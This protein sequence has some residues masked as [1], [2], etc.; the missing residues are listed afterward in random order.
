MVGTL[1]VIEAL[2]EGFIGILL[3]LD[4]II[5]WLIAGAYKIFMAIAGARL[6]SSD[7]YTEIANKIYIV[8]GVVMLFVL[9]YAILRGIID[10]EKETKGEFGSKML[11]RVVTAVIG[12]AIAPFLFNFMYQIQGKILEDDIIGRLFFRMDA[13]DKYDLSGSVDVDGTNVSYG[14]AETNPDEY[15]KS[16]GGAI[17]ATNLWQAFFF[18]AEG[19][20]ASEIEADAGEYF[21]SA[22]GNA[23]LCAGGIALGAAAT[24]IP[25]IGWI[26]GPILM[27]GTAVTAC[28]SSV[29]DVQAGIKVSQQTDGKVTL[30]EAYSIAAGSGEFSIFTAFIKNYAED[31]EI[32]YLFLVSTI[33]GAFALY[34]FVSFSIDMGVRAAMLAYLQIIAPIPLIL[35]VL[36]KF[37]DNL[38]KYISKV[39]GTF[40][41]VFVRIS[42]VYVVVY[43]IC[44][45]T[46]LF[47][48]VSAWQQTNANMGLSQVQQVLAL[49]LLILGL[50]AFCRKAPEIISETLNLPKGNMSLG[51]GKKLADGGYYSGKS[52]VGSGVKGAVNAWNN[53]KPRRGATAPTVGQRA[54]AALAGLGLSTAKAVKSNFIGP[55]RKEAKTA[56]EAKTLIDKSSEAAGT[57][58]QNMYG[59]RDTKDAYNEQAKQMKG[60]MEAAERDMST[61]PVGSAAYNTAKEK[62]E[63]ALKQ[64]REAKAIAHQ[65]TMIGAAVADLEERAKTWAVGTVDT[66]MMDR[67]ANFLAETRDLY[68][69]K[70]KSTVA[71][72]DD[73]KA[74]NRAASRAANES[75]EQFMYHQFQAANPGINRTF[76]EFVANELK[77]MD[78]GAAQKAQELHIKELED[79]AK[80]VTKRAVG[81]R[82]AEAASGIENDTSRAVTKYLNDHRAEF[83]AF[84]YEKIGEEE[85]TTLGIKVGINVQD[86]MTG[87]F[88]VSGLE[89]GITD[90]AN[91]ATSSMINNSQMRIS[92][93]NADGPTNVKLVV[94]KNNAGTIEYKF[95]DTSSGSDVVIKTIANDANVQE[96]ISRF[97]REKGFT[98]AKFQTTDTRTTASYDFNTYF[99][100]YISEVTDDETIVMNLKDASNS[101]VGAVNITRTADEVT[102]DC[103]PTGKLKVTTDKNGDPTSFTFTDSTGHTYSDPS[104][105][106]AEFNTALTSLFSSLGAT[107]T[108]TDRKKAPS[109]TRM[110]KMK[111]TVEQEHDKFTFSAEYLD[112]QMRRRN[113]DAKKKNDQGK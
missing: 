72:E 12:L 42:V 107:T 44:H 100:K 65:N 40:M 10:P 47:G 27:I 90:F 71:N 57:T 16:I 96:N 75:L 101:N 51:I 82:M 110:S 92:Y 8:I 81:R 111:D 108:A 66:T 21:A 7:A 78:K 103:G 77:S 18:P 88:G 64:Y 14:S 49:A 99:K 93:E 35:Q 56:K 62:Y 91:I 29:N 20:E 112:A 105:A 87:N 69:N 67:K 24:S 97:V 89:R 1:F 55:D 95:V 76:E 53:A 45:L 60:I 28:L 36:P 59:H 6:L 26:A 68:D 3:T 70:L 61:N 22:V 94:S 73:V 50:I 48:N 31:G 58:L 2:K 4:T 38:H 34:A 98:K 37:K 102:I 46:E 41:E 25:V 113:Q 9:S 5:Y 43:I 39:I 11:G 83:E 86:Y 109:N 19:Y 80:T 85:D 52:I 84:K 30:E 79:I 32:T 63:K 104:N 23:A 17:T 15:V 106:P 13:K 54:G 33:A 74:A